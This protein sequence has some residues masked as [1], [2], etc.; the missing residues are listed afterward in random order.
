MSTWIVVSPATAGDLPSV[1][2]MFIE[3]ATWLGM[4]LSFQHFDEELTSLPGKYSPPDGLILLAKTTSDG[5]AGTT[6]DRVAG[7]VALRRFDAR[8]C[9]MKR[10]WVREPFRKLGVGQL[11]VSS[12]INTARAAA[13]EAMVLDTLRSMIPARRLYESFGFRVIDPYYNNPLPGAVYL[14]LDL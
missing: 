3:Y 14:S 11:L 6:S 1:R 7:C 10:L 13:Y 8:R 12:I 2:E 9:E 4:D 5:A